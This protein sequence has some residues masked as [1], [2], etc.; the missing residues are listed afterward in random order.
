MN[1]TNGQLL[2]DEI[3]MTNKYVKRCLVSFI[4]EMQIKRILRLHFLTVI[5]ATIK[6]NNTLA[7]TQ[8]GRA[9]ILLVEL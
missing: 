4:R 6:K 7:K 9:N 2:E 1:A 3:Q 8:G 5:R